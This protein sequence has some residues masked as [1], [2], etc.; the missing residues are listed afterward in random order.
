MHRS[1][2]YFYFYLNFAFSDSIITNSRKTAT[3]PNSSY[4]VNRTAPY[5]P[6]SHHNLH[7]N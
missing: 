5:Y 3:N 6:S 7:S 2:Q 1:L 4:P